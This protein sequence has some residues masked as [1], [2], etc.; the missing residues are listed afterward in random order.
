MVSDDKLERSAG[1]G[2]QAGAAPLCPMYVLDI[3]LPR[4]EV[5]TTY[6]PEKAEVSFGDE[7]AVRFYYS[8]KTPCCEF[9]E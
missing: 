8:H 9:L 4:G 6:D 1:A 5:E 3:V 7:S 2:P